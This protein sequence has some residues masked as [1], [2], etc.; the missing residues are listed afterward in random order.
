MISISGY[1]LIRKLYQSSRSVIYQ[2]Y[3]Q[4]D[5]IPVILKVLA[6]EKPTPPQIH[7][8]QNEYNFT[9]KLKIKEIRRAVACKTAEG[10]PLLIMKYI[11]GKTL[12][13]LK[14]S[15]RPKPAGTGRHGTW[16]AYQPQ[17][18]TVDGW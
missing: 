7:Q 17:V 15:A 13:I 4:Q 2:G 3:S 14:P 6:M 12:K 8:F 5:N 10:K 11:E 9:C 18:C 1:T 16:F